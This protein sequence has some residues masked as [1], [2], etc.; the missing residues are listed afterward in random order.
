M[1]RLFGG[2]LIAV[3]VLM[4]TGSGLCTLAVITGSLANR[5]TD[6]TIVPLALFVGAIPFALGLGL[7]TIGR[8]FVREAAEDDASG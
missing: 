7:L 2:I 6:L 1:K 5:A 8:S 4:M 3:G